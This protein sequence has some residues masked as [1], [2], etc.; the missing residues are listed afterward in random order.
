MSWRLIPGAG[1][2]S[3]EDD[4]DDDDDDSSSVEYSD[5][6]EYEEE[7]LRA[8]RSLWRPA[9]GPMPGS[10]C[11][12]AADTTRPTCRRRGRSCSASK[13]R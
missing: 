1:T 4:G 6:D 11:S 8:T 10:F 5:G 3:E 13:R 12:P 2:P 9:G 7:D